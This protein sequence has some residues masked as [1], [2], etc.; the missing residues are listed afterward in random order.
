[1]ANPITNAPQNA[2]AIIAAAV[3]AVAPVLE[4]YVQNALGTTKS[5]VV[6]GLLTLLGGYLTWLV[7]NKKADAAP[8][9][10]AVPAPSFLVADDVPHDAG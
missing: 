6:Y 7:P 8:A 2:K 9:A 4:P 5:P 3:V 10:P 1:M